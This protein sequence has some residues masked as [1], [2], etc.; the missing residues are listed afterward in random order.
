MNS[1]LTSKYK[2]WNDKINSNFQNK[3][4]PPDKH[5]QGSGRLPYVLGDGQ[6]HTIWLVYARF[7]Q[8]MHFNA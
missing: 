5:S 8:Q 4:A 2:M 7:G 6:V 1:D 3:N